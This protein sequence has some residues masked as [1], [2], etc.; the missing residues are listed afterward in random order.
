MKLAFLNGG[1]ANQVFQYLFF[2]CGQMHHPE[3]EW[4]L[5]DSFFMCI[6]CIMVM[7]WEKYLGQMTKIF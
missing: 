5:D 4:I 1:L 6:R 2:R 3:E 7:N